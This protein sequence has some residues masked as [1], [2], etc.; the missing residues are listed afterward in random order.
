MQLIKSIVFT[1]LFSLIFYSSAAFAEQ[2][3]DFTYTE[4]G[5]TITITDYTCPGGAAVIPDTIDGK[6]VVRIGN[7]AFF[8]CA[9]L[10]G[11]TIP[12]SVTSIGFAAFNGCTGLATVTIPDN[13]TSI[14]QG[15]FYGCTGLTSVTKESV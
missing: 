9:A 10:T 2:W 1:S 13:V 7:Q 15:A 5:G 14:E 4:S 11:V 3:G 8:Q 12:G 6:P